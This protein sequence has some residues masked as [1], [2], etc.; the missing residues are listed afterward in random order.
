MRCDS[1][2]Y[3]SLS[4]SNRGRSPVLM[5]S[6]PDCDILREGFLADALH[7]HAGERTGRSSKIL[8]GWDQGVSTGG[9]LKAIKKLA[10][11]LIVHFV[12][13]PKA[14][15]HSLAWPK[16]NEERFQFFGLG[17][18]PHLGWELLSATST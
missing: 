4:A 9:H 2:S 1:N 13:R 14:L 17:Q 18:E 10:T 12:Q 3:V 16:S 11:N 6:S 5:R 15:C 8:A 7:G